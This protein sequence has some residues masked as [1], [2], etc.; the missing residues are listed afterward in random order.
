MKSWT[1]DHLQ[2]YLLLEDL[3]EAA[4]EIVEHQITG[5]HLCM[6]SYG[7]GLE[8]LMDKFF[9]SDIGAQR[10]LKFIETI[11]SDLEPIP[12]AEPIELPQELEAFQQHL[13]AWFDQVEYAREELEP[14]DKLQNFK[15]KIVNKPKRA[16]TARSEMVF[17]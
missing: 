3:E 7:W 12:L 11:Q 15:V 13:D 10:F 16:S 4:R 14:D 6:R 8:M 1:T 5:R 2:E 17:F 9:F